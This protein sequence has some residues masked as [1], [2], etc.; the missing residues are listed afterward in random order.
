[1]WGPTS[2][3]SDVVYISRWG[4]ACVACPSMCSTSSLSAELWGGVGCGVCGVGWVY[5][6]CCVGVGYGGSGMYTYG[7]HAYA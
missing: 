1:M 7:H 2:V 6:C 3:C 4:G 5:V